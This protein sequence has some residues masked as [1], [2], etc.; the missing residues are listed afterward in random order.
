VAALARLER[1]E[2]WL[3]GTRARATIIVAALLLSS[4]ALRL[5]M[6]SDDHFLS[7]ALDSPPK[8]RGIARAPWDLF[9][10]ARDARGIS[11]LM[12]E[13]VFPWWSDT[14]ARLMFFRPLS[15][16]T[17]WLD[18]ALWPG[19]PALMHL[20][21]LLWFAA[22]LCV[23]AAVYR[24]LCRTP[25]LAGLALALF[26]LDD[27]RTYTIAWICNR[28]GLIALVFG[29]M[30]LL[31]HDAARRHGFRAGYWL[32]PLCLA[33]GLL[34]G[35]T[36]LQVCAY[37]FAYAL[38]LDPGSRAA[39]A[40]SLL[41]Y[42]AVLLAWR[43]VYVGLGYGAVG[44]GLY[45][46]PTR[47]PLTFSLAVVER[48][49]V[50]LAA[51]YAG[52]ISELTD[53]LPVLT[54]R[55]APF[56][57]PLCALLAALV[58]ALISPLLRAD[59]VSEAKLAVGCDPDGVAGRA[60][61]ARALPVANDLRF[62]LLGSVLATLPV[63]GVS[64]TDRVLTATALGGAAALASLF[65]AHRESRAA[66]LDASAPH[67]APSGRWRRIAV[68]ALAVVHL[69]LSPLLLPVRIGGVDRVEDILAEADPSLSSAPASAA[70]TLVLLNPPLDPIAV[71]FPLYRASHDIQ[72]PRRTR[73]LTTGVS[74]LTLERPDAYTLRLT[75]H[76]GF[77]SNSSQWLLRDP[78]RPLRA[79]ERVKLEGVVFEVESLDARGRPATVSVRF[80]RPLEDPSFEWKRWDQDGYV[81][82]APPRPGQRLRVP[83]VDML[84]ALF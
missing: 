59:A 41:P 35:E 66:T 2:A 25:I 3:A 55:F 20:H 51:Q 4:G 62:W 1:L 80:D 27:A 83:A 10:F 38:L 52:V 30:A 34:G 73:W 43:A 19:Q 65:A 50:L 64:P 76:A 42:A 46:D 6:A 70:K 13:G 45:L 37:L 40:A 9:S 56:F 17:H 21:S 8:L 72:R 23:V 58:F 81:A 48:L 7:L 54:P 33:L 22:L 24:R 31:A 61:K 15:S 68:G 77:L 78:R 63:C 84:R 11:E 32:G 28:N 49:P 26:A 16:L 29:F 36:A 5:S 74:D 47:D 12:E 75:A 57:A 44:S 14:S 79:G 39:R 18:H 60:G 53:G 82:F 69:G 71:F 67:R